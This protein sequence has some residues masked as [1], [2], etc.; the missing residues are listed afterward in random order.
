MLT[1]GVRPRLD[2]RGTAKS[3]KTGAAAWR[4]GDGPPDSEDRAGRFLD[5]SDQLAATA[6]LVITLIRFAR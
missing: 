6:R 4:D 3:D 2:L 1:S 5:G